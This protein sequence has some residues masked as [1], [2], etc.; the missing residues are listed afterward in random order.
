VSFLSEPLTVEGDRTRLIQVLVNL[1]NNAAKYTDPGGE[2][3]VT[4]YREGADV[5][6]RVADTGLGIAPDLLPRVF[7]MFTQADSSL[8][9]TRGG[10]GIGLTLARQVVELHGGRISAASAGLGRGSEFI[11]RL[12]LRDGSVRSERPE[13]SER[14]GLTA[15]RRVLVIEDN[16]DSREMLR[17]SLELEGHVVE[18]AIDGSQGLAA[19]RAGTPDVVI[20]DIGLPGLDGYEVAR[21]IR[22]SVGGAVVL[23]ALTGYGDGEAQRRV[24]AAGFDVH[25]VKPVDPQVLARI[26]AERRSPGEPAA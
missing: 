20:V 6:V 8:A 17:I 1:L 3:S 11:V 2:V 5:V 9:H 19:A 23:I 14:P 24:A 25:L 18:T 12:P 7:D 16:R 13:A 10:L 22:Q 15:P 4:G 26:V 21:A